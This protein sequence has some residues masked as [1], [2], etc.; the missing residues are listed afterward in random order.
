MSTQYTKYL[1]QIQV[2]LLRKEKLKKY[3]CYNTTALFSERES[4][5]IYNVQKEAITEA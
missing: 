4:A 1:Q 2:L 3:S 5:I